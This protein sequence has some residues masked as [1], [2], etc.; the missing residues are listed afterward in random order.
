MFFYITFEK[1]FYFYSLERLHTIIFHVIGTVN[2]PNYGSFLMFF[3]CF[4]YHFQ[5]SILDVIATPIS[6]KFLD[7]AFVILFN[8][9]IYWSYPTT[10][11]K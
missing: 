5:I 3:S 8:V 6:L 2:R 1:K 9:L 4:Y 10:N 7:N 11:T